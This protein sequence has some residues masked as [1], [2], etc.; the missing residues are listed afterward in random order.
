M[1]G[2][3]L[4]SDT[5]VVADTAHPEDRVAV[6]IY[7]PP[8]FTTGFCR[9]LVKPLGPVHDQAVTELLAVADNWAVAVQVT[10][11]VTVGVTVEVPALEPVTLMLS[12][13]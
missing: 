5:V 1:S 7:C 9:A 13:K 6:T 11:P 4:F 12:K 10:V 8:A 3:V 2:V